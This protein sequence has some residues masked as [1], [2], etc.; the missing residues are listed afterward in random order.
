[1]RFGL[2]SEPKEMKIGAVTFKPAKRQPQQ[3]RNRVAQYVEPAWR[4]SCAMLVR[5]C[6]V[7]K[8]RDPSL[9]RRPVRSEAEHLEKYLLHVTCKETEKY[10]CSP[11]R[12]TRTF[13]Y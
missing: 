10:P 5:K 8:E 12:L 7:Q 11:E 9:R 1:M 13:H 6:W 4:S 3:G 2:T